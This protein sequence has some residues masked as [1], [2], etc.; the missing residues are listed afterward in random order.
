[1]EKA[2]EVSHKGGGYRFRVP[3]TVHGNIQQY[4]DNSCN[5][6]RTICLGTHLSIKLF[7]LYGEM[8]TYCIGNSLSSISNYPVFIS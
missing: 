7:Q 5:V 3:K 2:S 1:M 6:T 8:G 4:P